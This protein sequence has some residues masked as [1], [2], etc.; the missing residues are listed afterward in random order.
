MRSGVGQVERGSDRQILC[1]HDSQPVAGRRQVGGQLSA[2]AGRVVPQLPGEHPDRQRQVPAQPGYLP[3]LGP[4]PSAGPARPASRASSSAASSGDRVPRLITAASSSA[5]SRRRLV[6]R[7]R[8]PAR[9]RQEGPDLLVPG[10]VIQEQQDLLARNMVTPPARSRPRGRAGCAAR[11]HPAVSSRLAS[12]SAGPAGRLARGV[13]RA[14]GRKNCPSGKRLASGVRGVH[15]EGRLADPCHP[16][17][18]ADARPARRPP[19]M[20]A[21]FSS[22]RVSSRSRPV[23]LP[24]SRGRRPRRGRA[25]DSR[26]RRRS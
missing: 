21:S 3:G 4:A 7:T 5:I 26:A 14:A 2:R 9:A 22:S 20:P 15:G 12:A 23:K 16:V 11:R 25:D 1:A 8:L 18:H 17:D 6:T 10:R 19:A 24:M 13:A